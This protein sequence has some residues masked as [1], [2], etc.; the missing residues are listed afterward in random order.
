M[1]KALSLA[2]ALALTLG[3]SVTSNRA[4]TVPWMC[5]CNYCPALPNLACGLSEG[6]ATT[7][8]VYAQSNCGLNQ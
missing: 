3:V 1:S 7:C 5:D 2:A 8:S 6:G 4:Q